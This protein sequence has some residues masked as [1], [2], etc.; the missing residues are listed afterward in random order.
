M[1]AQ[2]RRVTQS[3]EKKLPTSCE[4]FFFHDGYEGFSAFQNFCLMV[5]NKQCEHMNPNPLGLKT[6]SYWKMVLKVKMGN[7]QTFNKI[8]CPTF[9][10]H[11]LGIVVESIFYQMRMK[12]TALNCFSSCEIP[13]SK[14]YWSFM[15]LGYEV[16]HVIN[17]HC[18]FIGTTGKCLLFPF[19]TMDLQTVFKYFLSLDLRIYGCCCRG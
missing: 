10:W 5:Y 15:E 6:F 2:F 19:S 17:S 14:G 11:E 4:I 9:S 3:W 18:I 13:G 7:F 1:R 8:M 16:L 12:H